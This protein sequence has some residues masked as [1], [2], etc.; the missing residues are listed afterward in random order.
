MG[1]VECLQLVV[2]ALGLL[3]CGHGILQQGQLDF[4]QKAHLGADGPQGFPVGEPP[5]IQPPETG[6]FVGMQGSGGHKGQ[7][8]F[9]EDQMLQLFGAKRAVAAVKDLAPLQSRPADLF[10]QH[11]GK[12]VGVFQAIDPPLFPDGLV[13]AKQALRGNAGEEA[14]FLPARGFSPGKLPGR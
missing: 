11:R 12:A 4:L 8:Q 5:Q 14:F 2:A 6:A 1:A 9:R 10:Q 3:Q 13:K 7:G